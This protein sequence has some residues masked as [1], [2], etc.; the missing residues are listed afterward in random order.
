M[1]AGSLSLQYWEEWEHQPIL[2]LTCYPLESQ[3]PVDRT[4]KCSRRWRE[5]PAPR[6][7]Y[8]TDEQYD[9]R[10][11]AYLAIG[12]GSHPSYN[13]IIPPNGFS[14]FE[15][16]LVNYFRLPPGGAYVVGGMIQ[17]FQADG[18]PVWLGFKPV[19]FIISTNR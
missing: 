8:E 3:W 9:Q 5:P 18:K 14:T 10:I 6:A 4:E 2:A 17:V 16:Q 12:L 13:Q 15:V 11:A 7:Y 19:T 1:S